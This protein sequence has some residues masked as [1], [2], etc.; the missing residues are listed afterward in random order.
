MAEGYDYNK[1][2]LVCHGVDDSVF[3]DPD[4]VTRS[5]AQRPG[6]RRPRILREERDRALN[7][8]PSL[9]VKLL[10]RPRSCGAQLNPVRGQIQ[11]RS[12]LTCSQGMLSPSSAMAASKAAMSSASSNA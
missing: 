8:R 11:P 6:R 12:T 2:H 7:P 9:W 10:K 5:S 4:S 3:P 1:E